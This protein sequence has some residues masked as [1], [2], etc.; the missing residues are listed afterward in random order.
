MPSSLQLRQQFADAPVHARDHRRLAL[1]RIGPVFRRR[2][3]RSPAPPARRP[4]ARARSL[5]AC[6]H[7][8]RQEEE[9]RPVLAP[10]DE[11]ARLVEEQV[12]GVLHPRGRVPRAGNRAD[13]CDDVRQSDLLGV[14]PEEVGIVVVRVGLVDEAVEVVEPVA[15]RLPF[16][17]HLAKAPLADERGGVAGLL[18]HAGHGHVARRQRLC[19]VVARA[20]IAAHAGVTH[21]PAGHE[22]AARRRADSRPGVELREADPLGRQ[23]IEVRRL[24]DPLPVRTEIAVAEV[25]GQDEDDVRPRRGLRG[26][27]C[28]GQRSQARP[29]QGRFHVRR[30]WVP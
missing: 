20:G 27:T 10:L 26:R 25:V 5:L 18:Q 7:R 2:R 15:F 13:G 22:H 21:V 23:P 4:S 17:A 3:D 19:R 16:G 8:Q 24:D 30:P 29:Q 28:G 9:E 12:V 1:E 6:G 14:P 11:G